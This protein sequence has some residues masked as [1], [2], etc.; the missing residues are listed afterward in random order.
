MRPLD[1]KLKQLLDRPKATFEDTFPEFENLVK[2]GANPNTRNTA[3]FTLLDM[4]AN[5]G[6]L[7]QMLEIAKLDGS[8]EDTFPEFES[9]VK[10]GA[11]PNTRNTAE[12]TLWRQLDMVANNT[13]SLSQMLKVAE[14]DGINA[15]KKANYTGYAQTPTF[16][17]LVDEEV[18]PLHRLLDRLMPY[19]F[20]RYEANPEK[21]KF[22]MPLFLELIRTLVAKGA[23]INEL[24][25]KRANLLH[26]FCLL[27]SPTGVKTALDLGANPKVKVTLGLWPYT[28]EEKI[29][30]LEYAT[31]QLLRSKSKARTASWESVS[32]IVVAF[33]EE[34]VLIDDCRP[35]YNFLRLAC[36]AGD[37]RAIQ[38]ALQ[39]GANPGS[40]LQLYRTVNKG[41]IDNSIV[42][43]LQAAAQHSN[44]YRK[45]LQSLVKQGTRAK[46]GTLQTEMIA[47]LSTERPVIYFKEGGVEDKII[48]ALS[49]KPLGAFAL[50][51]TILGINAGYIS[52]L[53][54]PPSET[55]TKRIKRV[56][57]L[58]EKVSPVQ[59]SHV[60][61]QNAILPPA[62]AKAAEE[63]EHDATTDVA[64]AETIP[65]PV[66]PPVLTETDQESAPAMSAP[67]TTTAPAP[68][69]SL[70][71]CAPPAI[72]QWPSLAAL[73]DSRHLTPGGND[74]PLRPTEATAVVSTTQSEHGPVTVTA[75]TPPATPIDEDI[76]IL[77]NDT[78]ASEASPQV[79]DAAQQRVD[80]LKAQLAPLWATVWPMAPAHTL[81]RAAQ[82][83][84]TNQQQQQS[85]TP[86]SEPPRAG[87]IAC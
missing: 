84:P 48:Q 72:S 28:I 34:G 86:D 9:L 43:E 82:A 14:L 6:S 54:G 45:K 75:G 17:D 73:V 63:Q 12:F 33:S 58:V 60:K 53:N 24:N 35:K 76:L 16:F 47:L 30:P 61:I 26:F 87:P 85:A 1:A 55:Y 13:G 69:T 22:D 23:D 37:A 36:L 42:E 7:S 27:S 65:T 67:L 71:T 70:A 4:V 21:L 59:T 49:D 51:D 62:H 77:F 64:A 20:L 11:N 32:E 56:F 52:S 5:T 68:A 38:L 41:K 31:S 74:I 25:H 29:S 40:A 10:A 2:A 78:P 18:S 80:A 46:V 3:G 81:E 79:P 50:Y 8:F 39:L 19:R 66:T 83:A 15:A 44:A 57:E